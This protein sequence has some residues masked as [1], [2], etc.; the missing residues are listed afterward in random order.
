MIVASRVS[1]CDYP[2][3][4][5]TVLGNPFRMYQESQR[6]SVCDQFEHYFEDKIR[7]NDPVIL[8]ELRKIKALAESKPIFKICC[9]CK[10]RRCHADTIAYFLNNYSDSI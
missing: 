10:P 7:G 2:V 4:R 5:K 6:D 9:H 8:D 3:D 1:D